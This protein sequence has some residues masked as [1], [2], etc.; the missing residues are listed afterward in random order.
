MLDHLWL[1]SECYKIVKVPWKKVPEEERISRS[2]F[3]EY[4]SSLAEYRGIRRAEQRTV[5]MFEEKE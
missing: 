5:E 1:R 4:F 3:S 2:L